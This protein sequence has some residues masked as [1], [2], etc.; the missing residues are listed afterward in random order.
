MFTG[1]IQGTG[2][3]AATQSVATGVRLVVTPDQPSAHPAPQLGDSVAVSGTCLTVSHI[4]TSEN[5]TADSDAGT[6]SWS[7]DVIPQT[8]AVTRLGDWAVGQGV[9]LETALRADDALGGHLVQ[10]HVDGMGE[11]MENGESKSDGWNLVIR[12]PVDLMPMMADKGSVTIDGVSLTLAEVTADTIRV[13]L[14]PT[15]LDL[16]TLSDLKPGDHVNLEADIITKA[17]ARQVAIHMAA[18]AKTSDTLTMDD[19]RVAGFAP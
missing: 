5:S 4:E 1:I 12:P 2:R 18:Q 7:F 11:V 15:T 16:T 13:S 9:N 17:V 10:G 14:I 8:L 3:I 6:V 19:M